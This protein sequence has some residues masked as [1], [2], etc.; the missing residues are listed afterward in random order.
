MK[1]MLISLLVGSMLFSV[2]CGQDYKANKITLDKVCNELQ[3]ITNEYGEEPCEGESTKRLPYKE[4]LSEMKQELNDL[5][6]KDEEDKKKYEVVN[7]I[8]EYGLSGLC[9]CNDKFIDFCD[10]HSNDEERFMYSSD[11]LN[12]IDKVVMDKKIEIS[13]DCK[14]NNNIKFIFEI[15]GIT[16]NLNNMTDKD[17]QSIKCANEINIELG[18]YENDN[19][20]SIL[21]ATKIK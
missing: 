3:I 6:F 5:K 15:D 9:T 2:G 1:K 11:L 19:E 18:Y 21:E 16:Y 12:N 13:T 20:I 8:I 10:K 7:K 14:F 17:Y 4:R